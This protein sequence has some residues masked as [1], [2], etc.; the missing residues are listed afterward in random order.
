M[1]YK[2]SI[3]AIKERENK[4]ISDAAVAQAQLHPLRKENAKLI[5]ENNE[6]H[7][8][9]IRQ[10]E[11]HRAE[12][13]KTQKQLRELSDEVLQYQMLFKASKDELQAKE[14]MIEKLRDVSG[15][16]SVWFWL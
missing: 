8:D 12:I 6:L 16:F 9:H 3:T 7:L 13:S 5:R 1:S 2:N 4:S 14:Q 11:H 10:V 15:L